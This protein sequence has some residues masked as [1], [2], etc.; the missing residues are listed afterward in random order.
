MLSTISWVNRSDV[1]DGLSALFGSNANQA[2]LVIDRAILDWEE[3][4]ANFNYSGGGNNYNLTVVTADLTSIAKGGPTSADAQKRPTAGTV[5]LDSIGTTHWIDPSVGDD[6]EFTIITNAFTGYAPG[7]VGVDLYATMVHEIGHCLGITQNSAYALSNFLTDSGVDDPNSNSAGNLWAFNVGGGPIE[8]TFTASDTGHLWEGP[9]TAP[10]NMAGLPFHVDDLMNPGRAIF[11]NERN[12]ISDLDATILRDAYGYTITM[13]ST[14][15][16]MLVNPNFTSDVL[17]VS[18][19]TGNVNDLIIVQGTAIPGQLHVTVG[20]VGG[21]PT[22]TEIV[23]LSQ[24]NSITINAGSG[25]D[26]VRIEYNGGKSTTINGGDGD[27]IFDFAFGTRQLS[28]IAGNTILNG[29]TGFNRVFTYDD[30]NVVAH[31]FTATS[32]RFDRPGWGGFFY[33][34]CVGLVTLTTGSAANV[35]NVE[36]SGPGQGIVLNSSGGSDT[37]NIGSSL[38]G[39]EFVRGDVQIQNDPSFTLININDGPSSIQR[40]FT[41]DQWDGNVGAIAGV[42]AYIT[43]DRSDVNTLNLTTGS[44]ADTILLRRTSEAF[45]FYNTNIFNVRDTLI[46]GNDTNGMQLITGAV[47]VGNSPGLAFTN[48][49]LNDTTNT[50][51]RNAVWTRVDNGGQLNFQIAGLAPAPIS[52]SYQDVVFLEV[53]GGSGGD[54]YT[55]NG[56]DDDWCDTSINGGGGFNSLTVDDRN[57]LWTPNVADIEPDSI[58]RGIFISYG[59][60]DISFSNI[61]APTYYARNSTTEINVHGVSNEIP[62]THQLTV[63]SGSGNDTLNLYP[64]DFLTGNLTIN[65]NFGYAGGGGL[66]AVVI[67]DSGSTLPI[68]YTFYNQFGPGTANIGGLGARGFGA[69]SDVESITINAGSG[70]DTFDIDSFK[71]GSSLAI[72]AGGGNDVIHVGTA[73]LPFSANILGPVSV[74]G[75]A[76]AD[77]LYV[78]DTAYTQPFNGYTIASTYLS[79]SSNT[80]SQNLVNFDGTLEDL[81]FYS[82]NA[83]SRF[84][85]VLGLSATTAFNLFGGTGFGDVLVVD[86]RTIPVAPFRADIGADYYD[87]YYGTPQ[88]PMIRQL[89]ARSGFEEFRVTAHNNTNTINVFAL[90]A[91]QYTTINGGQNADTVKLYPHDAEGNLTI[92]GGLSLFGAGGTDTLIIDDTGSTSPINYL[93]TNTFAGFIDSIAGFGSGSVSPSGVENTTILAGS[94]DDTFDFEGHKLSTSVALFGGDGNDTLEVAPISKNI[95]AGIVNLTNLTFD[96]GNGYDVMRLHNDNATGTFGGYNVSGRSSGSPRDFRRHTRPPSFKAPSNTLASLPDP[97]AISFR[98]QTP[99]PAHFTISTAEP[100]QW[101]TSCT[102][103]LSWTRSPTEST[104]ECASTA[105]AAATTRSPSTI[106]PT[107]SAGSCTS[108]TSRLAVRQ[109][110]TSSAAADSFNSSASPDR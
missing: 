97:R 34:S 49:T 105:R 21:G 18:G 1:S 104:A 6:A 10:T 28:N 36:S 62:S 74:I 60:Q 61:Q 15:N 107:Q 9:G 46:V 48:I 40:T 39:L 109:A 93:F 37:V 44:G 24:T 32:A 84:V 52:Y 79:N 54:S 53:L 72:N 14:I 65:G 80:L 57:M 2:R 100:E 82:S 25:N 13:P 83:N 92:N 87:E 89:S 55:F 27:D 31:T 98:F 78:D 45:N 29:G 35:V 102:S 30:N 88:S 70:D 69:A 110:T 64:R 86:D 103:V 47:Y 42:P 26:I 43:W 75:G 90:P 85:T 12:L 108:E 99:R 59:A 33:D 95:S 71:S 4:I 81:T 101:L 38:F 22:Y 51:G 58:H 50:V 91:S 68:N 106:T 76:G 16:N 96:G 66:D 20:T 63:I 56:F 23:P 5:T 77:A 67:Q 8:A 19:Q 17:T 11:G 73:A 3:V 7:L 41:I 94:G